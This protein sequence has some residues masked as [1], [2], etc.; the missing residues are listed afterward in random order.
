LSRE[1]PGSVDYHLREGHITSWLNYI[2]EKDAAASLSGVSDTEIALKKLGATGG[3][4]GRGGRRGQMQ[5]GRGMH[6][7]GRPKMHMMENDTQK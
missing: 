5:G 1:Y 4:G 6:H 3:K 2:G 7:P